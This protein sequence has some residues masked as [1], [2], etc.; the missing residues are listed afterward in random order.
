[1]SFVI[2]AVARNQEVAQILDIHFHRKKLLG[3]ARAPG[4]SRDQGLLVHGR[5]KASVLAA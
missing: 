3:F 1:V 5:F 4:F 2:S